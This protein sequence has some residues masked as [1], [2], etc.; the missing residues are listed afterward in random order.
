[1]RNTRVPCQEP[2]HVGVLHFFNVLLLAKE[3][4]VAPKGSRDSTLQNLNRWK[5]SR[6]QN[7]GK[8]SFLRTS[9]DRDSGSSDRFFDRTDERRIEPQ[10]FSNSN[11]SA[12]RLLSSLSF[13]AQ[14]NALL[15][16]LAQGTQADTNGKG[17]GLLAGGEALLNEMRGTIFWKETLKKWIAKKFPNAL[18]EQEQHYTFDLRVRTNLHPI[19]F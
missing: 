1:M 8:G 10:S 9:L 5:L 17:I 14:R 3:K 18:S 4:D 7:R 6:Q 13:P 11:D 16:Q 12:R 19:S 2:F 15:K